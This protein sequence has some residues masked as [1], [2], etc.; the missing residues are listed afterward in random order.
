[1]RI[2]FDVRSLQ[3]GTPPGGIGVYVW[4]LISHLAL[5]DRRNEYFLICFDRRPFDREWQFPASFT[6]SWAKVPC[7]DK[8]LNTFR[9]RLFLEGELRRYRLDVIHFPSPLSLTTHFDMG[10]DRG[11]C[12]LTLHDLT[13]LIFNKEIFVKKRALLK[14]LY[15]M[16]VKGLPREARYCAV[17]LHT[18]K[19]MEHYLS[20]PSEQITVIHHGI[21]SGFY[22]ERKSADE[23]RVRG[24]YRLP[25][26][27]LL[28]AGSFFPYKNVPLLLDA[29]GLLN[30]SRDMASA[31]VLAGNVHPFFR[32][33]LE[34]EIALRGL[35]ERVH[36]IG[37]V[38][39]QDLPVLYRMADVF[40]YPS[41]YEGF[42][43]P[44][45]EAMASGTPVLCSSA[46]SLPEVVGDGALLFDPRSPSQCA[47]LLAAILSDRA[48]REGLIERGLNRA[49]QFTW[50]KCAEKTLELYRLV[51]RERD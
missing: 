30:R 35:K 19:D 46:S 36:L 33:G 7:F 51:C 45:L 42:G 31:L 16:A 9:D 34:H 12:I 6:H 43:F 25:E 22:G 44:P 47:E 1:M 4:N 26:R 2:G 15:H 50:E 38:A 28:Y 48:R 8:F 10:K 49:R 39:S 17:S 32:E 18:K 37:H 20:L 27:F 40:I 13:P 3:A 5:M 29:I 14:P 23:E 11:K 41:L 24:A 21:G